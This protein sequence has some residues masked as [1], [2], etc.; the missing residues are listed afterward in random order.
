MRL[1]AYA[2]LFAGFLFRVPVFSATKLDFHQALQK[3]LEKSPDYNSLVLKDQ[4]AT[5]A[6]KSA[7]AAL[8]PTV[9]LQAM[10]LY[11]QQNSSAYISTVEVHA[12]WSNQAGV[13]VNENLYDNGVTWRQG[14]IADLTQNMQHLSLESGRSHLLVTVAKA[15]YDYSL[16]VEN[17][18][19]QK[20]QIETLKVQFRTIEGRYRQ[21]LSSNRD[22]LRIKAQLES[23]NIG[24]ISQ[25]IQVD[26]TKQALRQA[27]GDNEALEFEPLPPQEKMIK[28]AVSNINPQN[29]Y[30]FRMAKL[31]ND[32]SDI[33]FESA[34]RL[35][36]P[37]LSLKGGYSYTAP[38]FFGDKIPVIDDP[39]WNL[40]FMIV[41]NYRL[42]DWG[43]TQR[44][45]AIAANQKHI[46][47]NSQESIRIGVVQNLDQ[48]QSQLR[49]LQES[50]DVSLQII[51]AN[52]EAYD[53]L[54]RGYRDGKISYLDLITALST[55]YSSRTQ[56]LT[57][58]FT[59]MKSRLD[60]AYYEGKVDEVLNMP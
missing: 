16:A 7:W 28:A 32:I 5:M 21:G 10:D 19:L 11:S 33:T 44:G 36:W 29:T 27:I 52:Q 45:V 38:Q 50:C 15:F 42:W 34:R 22:Y 31:Q 35:E 2:L 51:K 17:A 4:N 43:S 30:E 49:K 40:Q 41:L 8:L 26:Q 24:L 12:P 48:L 57:L 47:D 6:A 39:Y 60:W 13:T 1:T 59:L 20:Q 14:Q 23:A 54:N 3:A 18:D 37:T 58:R 53:S 55:L 25:D 9:D 46:D 56:D